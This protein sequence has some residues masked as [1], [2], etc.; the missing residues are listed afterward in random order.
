MCFSVKEKIT[1]MIRSFVKE[2]EEQDNILTKWG[3]PLVGFADA[4]HPYILN[5]KEIITQR[6]M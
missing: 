3:E 1:N 5:L 2:Y 4:N 6:K